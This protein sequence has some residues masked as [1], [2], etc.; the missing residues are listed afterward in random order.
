MAG[1]DIDPNLGL[2][3]KRHVGRTTAV[4]NAADLAT[5]SNY[6]G[7]NGLYNRLQVINAGYYTAARLAQMSKND[8]I[9]A[10]RL[11]DDLAGL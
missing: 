4:K 3:D 8:M 6:S 9:Y 5:L 7:I 11:N 10:V 1:Y 2:S